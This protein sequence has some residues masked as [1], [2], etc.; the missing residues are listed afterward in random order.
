ME[1]EL[2]SNDLLKLHQ[3]ARCFV[4]L[5]SKNLWKIVILTDPGVPDRDLTKLVTQFTA[6]FKR[7]QM[8]FNAPVL[9]IQPTILCV[10]VY[11]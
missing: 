7:L 10:I 1:K 8:I 9:S 11:P 3:N 2:Q 6:V 4:D 5:Q